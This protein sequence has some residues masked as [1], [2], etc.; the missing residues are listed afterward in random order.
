MVLC[1]VMFAALDPPLRA[2][3]VQK[4]AELMKPGARVLLLTYNYHQSL[5]PGPPYGY[6]ITLYCNQCYD[7]CFAT[8]VILLCADRTRQ[9]DR[10][11]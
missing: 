2:A 7:E 8:T 1:P 4:I 6:A 3:Y 11:A 5:R 10:L 9:A